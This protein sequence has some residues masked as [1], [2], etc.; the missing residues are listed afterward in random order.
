MRGGASV[1][2]QDK[3]GN[4]PLH[5]AVTQRSDYIAEALIKEGSD[6]H[7]NA[8]NLQGRTCLHMASRF[9]SS[10]VLEQVIQHGGQI[11]AVDELGSTPRHLA[12]LQKRNGWKAKVLLKHG[13]DPEAVDYKD[14][15]P[16]HVACCSGNKEAASVLIDYGR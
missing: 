14:S 7:V 6:D 2:R 5:I 15:T 13:S 8:T 9:G 1:H 3:Q 11:D 4:T 10:R 16:L 12:V